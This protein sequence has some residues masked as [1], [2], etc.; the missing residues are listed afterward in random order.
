MREA[1]AVNDV[2]GFDSGPHDD[3]HF[4]KVGPNVGQLDGEGL[5]GSIELGR[6]IEQRS[7]LRM[8]RGE[9]ARAVRHAPVSSGI[10][11]CRHL[12]L[13]GCDICVSGEEAK[14]GRLGRRR[15]QPASP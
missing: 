1:K 10:A 6:P 2:L 7:A 11:N 5:L 12:Q 15:G 13:P 4:G 14:P 9:L 8:E 3:A